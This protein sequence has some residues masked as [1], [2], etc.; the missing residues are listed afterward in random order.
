MKLKAQKKVI[1]PSVIFPKKIKVLFDLKLIKFLLVLSLLTMVSLLSVYYGAKLQKDQRMA[2]I[3]QLIYNGLK[4]N[5]SFVGNYFQGVFS[6][7]ERIY[8]DIDFEGIQALNYARESALNKGIITDQEQSITVKALLTLNNK[9]YKVKVSPTGQN[10]DMIGSIDKRAYK[11]KVSGGK[12]IYGMS[13]FKLLPPSSRHH[14]VEWVGHELEKKE[15]LIALKYFFV[16]ASLNGKDLGVYAIEEHFNKELLENNS[17]RE[18]IIFAEK[19]NKIKVFNEKKYS[20]DELKN[21]QIQLLRAA[22]EGV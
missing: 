12:K 15:G 16:E 2:S 17:S 5:I 21:N 1:S 8:L 22:I 6:S 18:G 9:I 13:E 19:N 10:L 20:Q 4:T 3:Q 7:S 14:I 11:V